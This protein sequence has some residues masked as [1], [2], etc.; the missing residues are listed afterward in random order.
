[1]RDALPERRIK[2]DEIANLRE[3]KRYSRCIRALEKGTKRDDVVSKAREFTLASRLF[4]FCSFS[5]AKSKTSRF[6]QNT[7][8]SAEQSFTFRATQINK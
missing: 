6:E 4:I 2:N 7:Q 5:Q 1:M 8:N 3:K